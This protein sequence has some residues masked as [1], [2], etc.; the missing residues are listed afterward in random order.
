MLLMLI[1]FDCWHDSLNAAIT[2]GLTND[3][4]NKQPFSTHTSSKQG[5]KHYCAIDTSDVLLRALERA[6]PGSK[7]DK[8]AWTQGILHSHNLLTLHQAQHII[9]QSVSTPHG[10][11]Y[12]RTSVCFPIID[13][14]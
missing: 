3:T 7:A 5:T 11:L 13:F 2:L 10:V 8:E 4:H 9:H 6:H 1:L 14:H 12:Q